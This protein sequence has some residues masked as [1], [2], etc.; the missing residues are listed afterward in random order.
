MANRMMVWAAMG[1]PNQRE[2]VASPRNG[3]DK[4]DGLFPS[5]YT[6]FT[7]APPNHLA[8]IEQARL[9]AKPAA[10]PQRPERKTPIDAA[11]L[12]KGWILPA[13]DADTW[14]AA[15]STSYYRT[16]QSEDIDKAIDATR[17]QY[18]GLKFA[19]DN[20]ATRVRIE[21]A[22]GVLFLDQLRRKTGDDKFLALMNDFFAANT[23]KTVTAQ[24]FLDKAGVSFDF[25]EPA[26]GPVYAIADMNRRLATAIIVYGTQRE[27][28]ANSNTR[29]RS[30]RTLKLPTSYSRTTT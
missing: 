2:W 22:K 8:A 26:A 9:A 3:Y 13:S 21:E 16:L 19:A 15:G 20:A 29:C 4:N 28:G 30:I 7:G 12:W 6:L 23:T 27:A 5:G 17:I 24:S 18:R 10:A 11:R 1:K 14:F 25:V